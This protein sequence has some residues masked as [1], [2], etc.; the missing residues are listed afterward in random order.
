MYL[1]LGSAR[2]PVEVARRVASARVPVEV[3]RRVASA[4]RLANLVHFQHAVVLSGYHRLVPCDAQRGRYWRG[5]RQVDGVRP[6]EGWVRSGMARE[7]L[8]R[9][10]ARSSACR[11]LPDPGMHGDPGCHTGVDR[12]SRAELGDGDRHRRRCARLRG[13]AG[14]L[15]SEEQHAPLR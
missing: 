7:N 3:A 2:V 5:A 14:T 15:L 10:P 1:C 8:L 12:T 9:C 13:Q 4:G 11:V 6:R